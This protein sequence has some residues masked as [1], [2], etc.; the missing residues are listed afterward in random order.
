[1][2]PNHSNDFISLTLYFKAMRLTF[3][4]WMLVTGCLLLSLSPRTHAIDVLNLQFEQLRQG[5]LRLQ[6]VSLKLQLLDAQSLS[7]Q[8]SVERLSAPGLQQPLRNVSLNCAQLQETPTHLRCANAQLS[9]KNL[10]DSRAQK[11]DFVYKK[12]NGEIRLKFP[13]LLLAGSKLAADF[14]YGGT[15]W[16][17]KLRSQKLLLNKFLAHL[18]P[19]VT[20]PKRWTFGGDLQAEVEI[21]YDQHLNLQAQLDSKNFS[22]SN[23]DGTQVGENLKLALQLNTQQQPQHWAVEAKLQLHSGE[24]Y[25]EPLYVPVQQMA[26]L[27]TRLQWHSQRQQLKIT[28]LH[29]QHADILSLQA[30]T[31]LSFQKAFKL[32]QATLKI[33][34]FSVAAVQKNYLQTWL[35]DNHWKNLN[36]RGLLSLDVNWQNAVGKLQAEAQR[37]AVLGDWG[38]IT[39][40]SGILH[41]HSLH[42]RPTHLRWDGIQF[43]QTF[44][45]PAAQLNLR[46]QGEGAK[47]LTALHLPLLDGALHLAELQLDKLSS[48]QPQLSLSGRIEPISMARLSKTL[49]LPTL[50][51]QLAAVIPDISYKNKRLDMA[52]AL[53]LQVFDGDIVIHHLSL[54]DPLGALPILN[55]A[56]DIKQLDLKTL[57]HFF[58]FGEI[59]GRL[60]GY[61]KDLQLYN[62]QPIQFDAFVG[63][64]AEGSGGKISQKAVSNL[65]NLGGGGVADTLSR[66]V[67]SIFES[68]SYARLGLG[69][70]LRNKVCTMRGAEAAEGGYYLVKGG[71][72]PRIDVKGFNQQV[73]WEVLLER[74]KNV[75]NLG[76]PVI[77]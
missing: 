10:L 57:T 16:Q 40:L 7:L 1:M 36:T 47:L 39:G 48:E 53:L 41:W 44:A 8:A 19:W 52:G 49:G 55:A 59:S 46:L 71:G 13:R 76:A 67:L 22:F 11:I 43:G 37:L 33:P 54:Q 70:R 25:S 74:L 15:G 17:V 60:S 23:T 66:G 42:A 77:Q 34:A 5:E 27:R 26:Q 58:E 12:I 56:I 50:G 18:S 51:G 69:C 73:D 64:P 45:F 28:D 9:I 35:E 75:T 30:S 63:T 29:Y 31:T 20:L 62:W 61:V 6:K 2:Y 68:F 3:S 21:R 32:Q 4:H 14:S 65:S 38:S 24:L 72:L